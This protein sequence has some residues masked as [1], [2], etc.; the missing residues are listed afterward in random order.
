MVV[1]LNKYNLRFCCAALCALTPKHFSQCQATRN[2]H[3]GFGIVR[4]WR[5]EVIVEMAVHF[6]L[7]SQRIPVSCDRTNLDI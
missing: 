1:H 2:T 6:A 3:T 7:S 4:E 5:R